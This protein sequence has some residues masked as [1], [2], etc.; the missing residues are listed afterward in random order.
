L[1]P[2]S[3]VHVER[4]PKLVYDPSIYTLIICVKNDYEKM[5]SKG[6]ATGDT[7][8]FTYNAQEQLNNKKGLGNIE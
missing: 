5:K 3:A 7:S 8:P 1:R 4:W 2:L 6:S